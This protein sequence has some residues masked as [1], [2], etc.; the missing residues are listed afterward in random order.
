MILL[1]FSGGPVCLAMR[2]RRKEFISGSAPSSGLGGN[3]RQVWRR[4]RLRRRYFRW[5]RVCRRYRSCLACMP[6]MRSMAFSPVTG[7]GGATR[8][9]AIWCVGASTIPTRRTTS[10]Y[11]SAR[12]GLSSLCRKM[13]R[14]LSLIGR[15]GTFSGNSSHPSSQARGAGSNERGRQL[16]RPKKVSPRWGSGAHGRYVD[17]PCQERQRHHATI[18]VVRCLTAWRTNQELQSICYAYINKLHR[19]EIRTL[20]DSN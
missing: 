14:R 12:G 5:P 3:S 2:R 4:S 1:K 8:K 13:I 11:N 19:N 17:L 15:S 7:A 9:A 20:S 16:R 6:S 18:E 10:R